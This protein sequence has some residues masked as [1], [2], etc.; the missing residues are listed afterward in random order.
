MDTGPVGVMEMGGDRIL[1]QFYGKLNVTLL[2]MTT[3]YI[4]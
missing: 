4:M 3:I 1:S 2:W